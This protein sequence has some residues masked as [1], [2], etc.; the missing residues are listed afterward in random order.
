M[1]EQATLEAWL[2]LIV[3]ENSPQFRAFGCLEQLA[4]AS[5]EMCNQLASRAYRDEHA[6]KQPTANVPSTKTGRQTAYPIRAA[7]LNLEIEARDLTPN[8]IKVLGGLD[9][10][11]TARIRQGKRVGPQ[12]LRKLAKALS[13]TLDQIPNG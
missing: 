9:P 11:T 1:T 7:W 4:H 10:R 3:S 12:V 2:D 13:I 8:R 5:A 6:S